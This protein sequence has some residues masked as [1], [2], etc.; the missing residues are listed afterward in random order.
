MIVDPPINKGNLKPIK[1]TTGVRATL[2]P[3]NIFILHSGNPFDLAVLMNSR[4][5]TSSIDDRE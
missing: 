2:N 1:T 5:S 3:C 4:D